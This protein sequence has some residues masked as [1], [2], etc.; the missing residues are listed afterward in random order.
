MPQ[1]TSMGDLML[2]FVLALSFTCFAVAANAEN[3]KEEVCG[4]QGEI[5]GAIQQARL[6]GVEE[7]DVEKAITAN[8]PSWP[9]N[10]S[11][12]IPTLTQWV[13]Q[14]DIALVQDGDMGAF[15]QSECLRNWEVIQQTL[16]N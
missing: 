3:T 16:G 5:A 13:Y 12:A 8:G 6:Q 1:T 10:Y 11:K 14:T 4:F 7:R 9:E 2:R 15:W